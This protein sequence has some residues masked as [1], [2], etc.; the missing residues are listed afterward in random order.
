VKT[1]PLVLIGASEGER[2]FFGTRQLAALVKSLR[3]ESELPV[4]LNA[5]HTHSLGKAREAAN[6]GFDLV[7]IDFSAL[8][9]EQNV[10]RTKE[11]VEV[12][13]AVN[14][15]I[16]VE[17]EIGD[18]GTGSE[19]HE[20]AQNK[21]GNLTTP[22]EARQFARETGI[23]LLAPAVGNMHGMSASM[24]LGKTRKRLDIERI[25]QIKK[26]AGVFLTLHGGSGTGDEDFRNAIAAG[27]NVIHI[28][29]ELRVAWRQSLAASL[30]QD[31]KE[32][33]PYKILPPVVDSVK[34]V[35]SSRL[36]LFQARPGS[37]EAA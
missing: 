21:T 5:D 7:G 19:I 27:I 32:V 16:V 34:Q 30:A 8:P 1:E 22:E 31:P 15:A 33:V 9:F 3:D 6:A 36:R 13:K 18:I 14:P 25:A 10:A 2:D 4:F 12:V 37:E 23:D 26:A 29:T 20:A 28:N 24:V 17:G 11:A 35:V